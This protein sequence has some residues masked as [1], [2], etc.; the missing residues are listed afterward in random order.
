MF[1]YLPLL[2]E[3]EMLDSIWQFTVAGCIIYIT[4]KLSIMRYDVDLNKE[5]INTMLMEWDKK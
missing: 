1:Q 5:V 2:G 4:I 3:F